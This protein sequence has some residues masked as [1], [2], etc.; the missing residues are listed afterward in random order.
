[1]Q[2]IMTRSSDQSNFRSKLGRR[3][4]LVHDGNPVPYLVMVSIRLQMVTRSF[5]WASIVWN[6]DPD[7]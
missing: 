1:M 2:V 6:C 7:E 5:L 3:Q 4:H